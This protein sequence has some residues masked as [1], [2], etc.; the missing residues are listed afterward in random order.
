MS[1]TWFGAIAKEEGLR[2]A[3]GGGR[4][5]VYWPDV[6][7]FI[8]RSRITKVN[9]TVRREIDPDRRLTGIKVMERV[10]ARCGWSDQDIAYALGV[11]PSAVSRY[12]LNGVP[13]D[14]VEMLRRLEQLSPDQ[15]ADPGRV[16]RKTWEDWMRSR[17]KAAG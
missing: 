16:S 1:K 13:K 7:A 10:K 4:P 12:R 3:P 6:E 8:E 11:W 2:V 9:D 5:G 15:V 17:Q 14:Q